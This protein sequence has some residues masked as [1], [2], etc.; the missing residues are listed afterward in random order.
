MSTQLQQ[1]END[2]AVLLMYLAGELAGADRAEVDRRL[3]A[4]AGL[5]AELDRLRE[6]YHWLEAAMAQADAAAGPVPALA[7]A[8]AVRR[9][10][11]AVREWHAGRLARPRA[12]A[13]AQR[14]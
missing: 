3:A 4:D 7:K 13:S 6:T 2:Q 14:H 1:L 9:V 5:R 12:Q 10:G 8:A 11:R